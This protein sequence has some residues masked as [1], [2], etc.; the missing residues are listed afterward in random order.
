MR[1]LKTA[2]FTLAL[3]I[4]GGALDACTTHS[5]PAKQTPEL[6]QFLPCP[7]ITLLHKK[8]SP[9]LGKEMEALKKDGHYAVV[10]EALTDYHNVRAATP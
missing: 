5:E 6:T 3:L 7:S 1:E 4:T 2:A 9:E 10:L 8:Y